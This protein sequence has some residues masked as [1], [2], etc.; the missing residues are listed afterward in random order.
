MRSWDGPGFT[1]Y[2][3]RTRVFSNQGYRPQVTTARW[4]MYLDTTKIASQDFQSTYFNFF[5]SPLQ[6]ARYYQLS[7]IPHGATSF[8]AVLLKASLAPGVSF[9]SFLISL[10][11]V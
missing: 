6:V 1:Y 3:C 8:T 7:H 11:C 9:T 10:C 2:A 5:H 4:L